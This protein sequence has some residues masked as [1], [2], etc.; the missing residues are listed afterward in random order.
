MVVRI[1]QMYGK[2]ARFH[3]AGVKKNFFFFIVVATQPGP[4]ALTVCGFPYSR[5]SHTL[6]APL[7][8][9]RGSAA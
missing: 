1:M 2:T 7:A 9:V 6:L 3:T 8:A 5:V 4:P